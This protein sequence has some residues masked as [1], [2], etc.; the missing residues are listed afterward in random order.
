MA[1]MLD[2]ARRN[3]EIGF[4]WAGGNLE[5]VEKWKARA[6][7]KGIANV[8]ILGFVPNEKLPLVQAACEVLL[9]PYEQV[10][11]VSS[12]GDTAATASPMKVFEYLAS[13][14]AIL[15]SDLPVIR[16]VLSQQ[17]AI[18]L[19]PDAAD[20]WSSALQ[21]LAE[22]PDRRAALGRRARQDARNY[23]WNQR[24]ERAL[25]GFPAAR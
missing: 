24:A 3:P 4:L 22:D 1:L 17:N 11:A 6:A 18:L 15:S 9:M 16:E 21:Q 20:E 2:L 23:T 13:G 5:S 7:A 25:G 19:P 12:G 10:I 8:E 14:R